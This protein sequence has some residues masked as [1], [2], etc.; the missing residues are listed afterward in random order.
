[1]RTL[2][3]WACMALLSVL[4]A[5]GG[6]G[7][8][9]ASGPT[10]LKALDPGAQGY[11]TLTW[12]QPPVPVDFYQVERAWGTGPFSVLNQVE[13]FATDY[14]YDVTPADPDGAIL[15]FRICSSTQG[16]KS[17][18]SA[19]VSWQ[20]YIRSAVNLQATA[21]GPGVQLTW[22]PVAS[23]LTAVRVL[24][25]PVAFGIAGTY[26]Q[27]AE[28]PASAAQYLDTAVTPGQS[29][30]YEVV[31]VQGTLT[32]RAA[33]SNQIP[34]AWGAPVLDTATLVGATVQLSWH[35]VDPAAPVR[36][37]RQATL[38]G[39]TSATDPFTLLATLGIG[40]TTYYDQP[41]MPAFYVYKV[42]GVYVGG[43]QRSN[44][45]PVLPP[46]SPVLGTFS[47]KALDLPPA[48]AYVR[49]PGGDWWVLHQPLS[50]SG[51]L[52]P[53][54]SVG[55]P[56]F[57]LG[58]TDVLLAPGVAFTTGGTPHVFLIRIVGIQYH[59]LQEVLAAGAWTETDLG[60]FDSEGAPTGMA[61]LEAP[62][63]FHLFVGG[64]NAGTY[65]RPGGGTWTQVAFPAP[66][67]D[68][69]PWWGDRGADGQVRLVRA[70]PAF[71]GSDLST[72]GAAGGWTTEAVP[73]A[74]A[75]GQ[76]QGLW[77]CGLAGGRLAYFSKYFSS[78]SYI[79]FGY[80]RPAGGAWDG[81]P[82]PGWGSRDNE[83]RATDAGRTRLACV[84]TPNFNSGGTADLYLFGS[85]G[86]I[87][88]GTFGP[89]SL[90]D[91]VRPLATGFTPDGHLWVL[92]QGGLPASGATVEHLALYEETGP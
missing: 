37:L 22:N 46:P 8:S 48:E 42:E 92:Y 64:G 49:D 32:S 66:A 44:G 9:P 41:P 29:Y 89:F 2:F 69:L 80:D 13:G 56:A 50:G 88:S 5:C 26:A 34:V 67:A 28:L 27:I 36:V 54:A 55:G 85:D 57:A 33:G 4:T 17:A 11:V 58:R 62:D 24:R 83:V 81:G 84:S 31:N 15:S 39:S 86:T 52:V 65:Y 12:D 72:L 77:L 91:G 6:G 76:A 61:V 75:S 18:Y 38:D 60:G 74:Q 47:S 43:A 25:A 71:T 87:V 20:M 63:R 51:S 30:A 1:M 7:S 59:L 79:E 45:L 16:K 21:S 23:G 78:G 40:S 70:D 90:G 82:L 68:Y 10:G 35:Q 14:Q 3:L 53:P 19:T 73:E